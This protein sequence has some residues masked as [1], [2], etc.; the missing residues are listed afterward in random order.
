MTN[1]HYLKMLIH[2]CEL[3]A[4]TTTREGGELVVGYADPVTVRCRF[5]VRSEN[6]ADASNSR[7]IAQ[8]HYLMLTEDAPVDRRYRVTNIKVRISGR[9]VDPGPFTITEVLTLGNAR[10]VNHLEA[11]IERVR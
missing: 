1:P 2:T 5:A 11:D 8:R 10:D 3:A 6:W 7:A 4:P 9:V